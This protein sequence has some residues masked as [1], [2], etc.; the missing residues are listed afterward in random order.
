MTE[1]HVH[2]PRM[3]HAL[4]SDCW[5]EPND[6]RIVKDMFTEEPILVVT[7]DDMVRELNHEVV[8]SMREVDRDRACPDFRAHDAWITRALDWR[9]RGLLPPH[10]ETPDV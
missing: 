6:F 4:S 5:C 3:G 10:E 9:P 1:A 2:D 7:H 8:L